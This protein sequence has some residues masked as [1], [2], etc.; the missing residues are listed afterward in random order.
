MPNGEIAYVYGCS[1]KDVSYHLN[2]WTM[3]DNKTGSV[4]I[5]QFQKWKLREDLKDFLNPID[6]RLPYEFDL[7][8]DLKYLSDLKYFI[9]HCSENVELNRLVKHYKIEI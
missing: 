7:H 3:Q 2:G 1:K 9:K 4:K 5:K 8:Y 6:P